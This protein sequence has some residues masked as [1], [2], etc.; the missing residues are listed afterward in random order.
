MNNVGEAF[1]YVFEDAEWLKKVLIGGLVLLT[2]I[3]VLPIPLWM[4][5][6]IELRANVIGKKTP[7]LPE[8]NNLGDKYTKGLILTLGVF[9]Y[10]LFGIILGKSGIPFSRLLSSLYQLLMVFYL[11][12]VWVFY[13]KYQTFKSMF[14]IQEI[15][16]F[17]TKN[18]VDLL[19]FWLLHFV[20]VFVSLL[21]LLGL[22][23]G[24]VFTA[25]YSLLV[26]SYLYSSLYRDK[27]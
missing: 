12:I 20:L 9:L 11:P 26:Q 27:A 1:S 7:V 6:L 2:S 13:A 3:F 8:W 14:N 16:E 15:F 24:V 19:V 18:F 5:Y 25:F 22:V 17:V 10:S 4:G 21:G 23:I